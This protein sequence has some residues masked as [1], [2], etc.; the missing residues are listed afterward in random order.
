MIKHLTL[1]IFLGLVLAQPAALGQT[2]E[3]EAIE[4]IT[5]TGSFI[6]RKSQSDT[7]SPIKVLGGENMAE[8]AAFVPSDIVATLTTNAGS[9]NQNDGLNQ[10]FSLGTTNI[11]LRG[12]GV[13]STLTL[14]NGRRQTLTAATTLN[15]DQ[16]VDLNSL[17]PAIAID[18]VEILKDGASTLYGSDAVAGVVNFFTRNDFAGAEV[19]ASYASTSRDGQDDLQVSLLLGK[20]FDN[21]ANLIFAFSYFD[22]SPLAAV[23]RRDE[24]E[25][26][27]A[28]SIFGQ[29]G[30]YLVFPAAG[31]PIRTL[32]PSCAA[33]AAQ[34]PLVG[35]ILGGPIAPTC[36]FDFGDAFALV[37]DEQR[38]QAYAH[39][40]LY[41][42]DSN[43][44]F[45][46]VGYTD[47][48]TQSTTSPSQPIL[49]PPFIPETNPVAPDIGIP[50]G[51]FALWFGRPDGSGAPNTPVDF[52]NETFRIAGGF[53]GE[54]KNGWSW[55][56]GVT[57]SSNDNTYFDPSDIKVD[58]FGAALFGAGGPS[59]N[60][61]YNPLFGATNDPV[62][63]EDFRGIYSWDA[64]STLLTLDGHITGE[65]GQLA[66]GPVGFAAG[67]QYREDELSYSYSQD[68]RDDNL[69]FFIGN[70]NFSGTQDVYAIFIETDLPVTDN[71]SIQA[72]VRFEDFG[73]VD[74]T[75]PK[76]GF[77]W[78]PTD[79]L[80][81]RGTYGSSFRAPSIFQQAGLFRVPARIFDP[82]SGGFATISQ[83]T[84]A[85]P[86]LALVPQVSDTFNLGVTWDALDAGVTI[87][88]DYW[89][90]EYEK[91]ITPENATALVASDPFG[92]QVTRDP[93]TQTLLAVSTFYR[94]AGNL[95][96]DGL[97]LS[98]TKVW[99]T[100]GAGE[101]TLRLDATQILTYDLQDPILG[102]VDGLGQRNFTNFGVPTPELRG[103]VGLLWSRNSHAANVFVRYIDSYTDEN[104]LNASIDSYS[105][106]DVQ[107]RFS[108]AGL[109]G[110]EE[111][112][113][114]TVGAKNLFDEM[115]PDVVSRTGY[116]PLTHN[117]LGRQWYVAIKQTF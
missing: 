45:A 15:G 112:P 6:K 93:I 56:T 71:L 84:E 64:E 12:L 90:F 23:E 70:R 26:R 63:R 13:S 40:D 17:V 100:A 35:Q 50:A 113:V 18:R 102:N 116:D 27:D 91:F 76:I 48:D 89:R 54:F 9:Q 107:Y 85:D 82:I 29:P 4:E 68:A 95:D 14:L 16:F 47:N 88:L 33:V 103:N 53:D 74:T 97:D 60:Q 46:E 111:G 34:D 22:R 79:G 39:A 58:R 57:F 87:S 78:R 51:G 38:L 10:S 20:N 117:P 24:F 3:G 1:G 65:F 72:A 11:N 81:L 49:F 105:S 8:V 66:G 36:T 101:F 86:A 110:L 61:F 43:H 37:A 104:N 62:V 109:G 77:L 42:G 99:D 96:T 32:D 5:V 67:V 73:S 31:P 44:F 7:T 92:P 28:I 80:S 30:T 19:S 52:G 83:Q 55:E 115:P 108:I 41:F 106:V 98:V 25:L 59:N 114:L 2:P 69:Y 21:D 75:D 94:N